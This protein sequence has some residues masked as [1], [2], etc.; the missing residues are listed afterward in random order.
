MLTLV[1][2]AGSSSLKAA[3]FDQK[4]KIWAGQI[5]EWEEGSAKAFLRS[6]DCSEVER[7]GHRFVHGGTRFIKPTLLNKETLTALE[8]LN[9][10]APLHNPRNLL[11]VKVAQEILPHAKQVAVFDTAFHASI[12]KENYLYALP[13][14]YT[15]MGIRRFGFHGLSHASCV[16]HL[17]AILGELPRRVISCHLG[18]GCSI[19]AVFEGLSIDTTMG[20]T[21]MEGMIMGSRSGSIDPGIAFYLF[22][23]G[24]CSPDMLDQELNGASGLLG[25][26]GT[27][28]MR[29]IENNSDESSRLGLDLFTRS[30]AKEVARMAVSLGGV[31]ALLFTGGIGENSAKVREKVIALL[32]FLGLTIEPSLNQKGEEGCLSSDKRVFLIKSREAEWIASLVEV[33]S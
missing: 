3:L 2:N 14:K 21:P 17:K 22:R 16:D 10:L 25:L 33:I 8:S 24:I 12:P 6:I 27:Q 28:D 13:Q 32:P 20:F 15:E 5:D 26:C 30:C 19:A 4:K 23:E 1:I 18:S 9:P 7:V 29:L 31:D 11:G